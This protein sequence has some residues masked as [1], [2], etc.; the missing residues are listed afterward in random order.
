MSKCYGHLYSCNQCVINGKPQKAYR[1]I[2]DKLHKNSAG[3]AT[4]EDLLALVAYSQR[5]FHSC[6]LYRCRYLWRKSPLARMPEETFYKVHIQLFE[7]GFCNALYIMYTIATCTVR[8]LAYKC[9]PQLWS[10]WG[11]EVTEV[12][13]GERWSCKRWE[14]VVL[15]SSLLLS[16]PQMHDFQ[17]EQDYPQCS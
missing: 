3:L 8:L 4:K 15:L 12:S 13:L 6:S 2:A 1:G 5:P 16:S 14:R 9:M 7:L 17:E 11:F 10:C